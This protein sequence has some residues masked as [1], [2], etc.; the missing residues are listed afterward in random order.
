M[1]PSGSEGALKSAETVH[2]ASLVQFAVT[3]LPV[4]V[5]AGTRIRSYA[6][7]SIS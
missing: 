2:V 4:S 3:S 7:P 1:E 6:A 5:S